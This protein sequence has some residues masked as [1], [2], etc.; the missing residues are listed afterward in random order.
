MVWC[1]NASQ[2]IIDLKYAL[3]LLGTRESVLGDFAFKYSLVNPCALCGPGRD[4][5][6]D[7][8]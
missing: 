3:R 1:P 7:H 5:P 2:L 4:G 6:Y 8:V